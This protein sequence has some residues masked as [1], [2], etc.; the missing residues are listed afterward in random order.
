MLIGEREEWGNTKMAH[1]RG[2]EERDEGG[3]GKRKGRKREQKNMKYESEERQE[4][5]NEKNKGKSKERTRE[6]TG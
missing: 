4:P 5:G 1:E 2:W 3:K 6:S